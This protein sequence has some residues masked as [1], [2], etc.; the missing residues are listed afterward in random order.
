MSIPPYI[1]NADGVVREGLNVVPRSLKLPNVGGMELES[2]V[3]QHQVRLTFDVVQVV[4][5]TPF[6]LRMLG[7]MH[8]LSP[9]VREGLGPLLALYP[10]IAESLTLADD[11]TLRLRFR[12]GALVEVPAAAQYEAW[13]VQG[14]ADFLAVCAPG[15]E[16]VMLWA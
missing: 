6:L 10:D 4:I 3:V 14:P 7:E 12:S 13:Q 5:E 8:D 9:D 2:I 15:G 1:Q 11:S 16:A